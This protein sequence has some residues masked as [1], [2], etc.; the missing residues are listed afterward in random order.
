M[1]PTPF[2]F[3]VRQGPL[4]RFFRLGLFLPCAIGLGIYTEVTTDESAE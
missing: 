1:A 3:E 2:L 4:S